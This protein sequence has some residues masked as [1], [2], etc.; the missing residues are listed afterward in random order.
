MTYA[1]V[2]LNITNTDALAA[3]GAQA[4]AALAKHG[5]KVAAGSAAPECIEGEAPVPDRVVILEFPDKDAAYAWINDPE[6]KDVHDLRNAIG[7]CNIVVLG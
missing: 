7:T 4:G 5:A 1:V 6:L 3:Y 2:T